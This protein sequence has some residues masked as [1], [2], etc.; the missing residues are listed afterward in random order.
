MGFKLLKASGSSGSSTS[1]GKYVRTTRF[2]IIASGTSGTITKP[3]SS[4]IILDD[5]GGTTDAVVATSSSSLPNVQSSRTSSGVVVATSFD[6]SGNWSLTGTPAAY[7]IAIVYRVKQLMSDFDSTASDIWGV[8]TIEADTTETEITLSDI[9]TN[10]SS[11]TNHGFL[12]KLSNTATEFMNG[13]GSW[14]VPNLLKLPES[15]NSSTP[16]GTVTV[17]VLTATDSASVVDVAIVPKSTGAF[18]LA[19][20]DNGTG[21]G[22]KRGANAIDL[23]LE[24]N[25]NSQVPNG[26]RSATLGSRNTA[27]N[28]AAIA[29]GNTNTAS[30][31]AATAIGGSNT[32]S[33]TSSTALGSLC[34][35][36]GPQSFATGQQSSTFL[37][38]GRHAHSSQQTSTLGDQQISRFVLKK[39]TTDATSTRVTADGGAASAV[40]QVVLQNTNAFTFTGMIIGKQQATSTNVGSWK[41]EG[42]IYRAA[43]AASTTLVASTVTVI[44][45]AATFGTPVLSADTTNGALAINVI[46]IDATNIRWT[47]YV[48][49]C[50]VIY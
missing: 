22:N 31:V 24:R 30:G 5:F 6:T 15:L 47:V 17:A 2:A 49:T 32:A 11:T 25:V 8:A 23:Q 26:A 18:M 19:I 3:T 7:P 34:T 37:L 27:S 41:I 4:T 44:S 48:E 40:N 21:G 28:T 42:V 39:S 36:S 14:A 29:I 43:N 12:K 16:N 9:T 1:D 13:V 35:A 45:N 20:P 46:G 50:E 10:D 33:G 38:Y